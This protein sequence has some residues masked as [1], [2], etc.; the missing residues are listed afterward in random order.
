MRFIFVH[1]KGPSF[2]QSLFTLFST[3]FI[4]TGCT[5]VAQWQPRNDGLYGGP[6][7]ELA[8]VGDKIFAG[9]FFGLYRSDDNATSWDHL[10][11]DHV[12]LTDLKVVGT[13]IYAKDNQ[14][15]VYLLND[16]GELKGL[17]LPVGVDYV[18]SFVATKT[19]LFV[20]S[21][22]GIYSLADGNTWT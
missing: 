2:R 19:K 1:L 6:V 8:T 7:N 14:G 20:G 12:V 11:L 4:L 10:D 15:H 18:T 13:S 17:S 3:I 9:T 5:A 22:Q 21:Y 16:K